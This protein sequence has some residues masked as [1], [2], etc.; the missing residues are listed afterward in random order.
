MQ[1]P[2]EECLTRVEGGTK[3][4]YMSGAPSLHES[5]LQRAM[6]EAVHGRDTTMIY[7]RVLKRGPGAVRR[8]PPQ[9]RGRH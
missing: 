2:Q 3:F 9:Q 1:I 5:V 7:T 8:L 6:Q 4:C